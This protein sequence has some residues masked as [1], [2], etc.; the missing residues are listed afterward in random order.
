MRLNPR[1]GDAGDLKALREMMCAGYPDDAF[2]QRL[3]SMQTD[4]S[5]TANVGRAVG[6]AETQGFNNPSGVEWSGGYLTPDT[7]VVTLGGESQDG[8]EWFR[9]HLINVHT[10]TLSG[11]IGVDVT[12]PYELKPLGGHAVPSQQHEVPRVQGGRRASDGSLRRATALL[13]GRST[14]LSF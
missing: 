5:T 8:D 10:G 4:E 13:Q 9:Y 2:R 11:E 12:N 1:T 7:A 14:P 3:G 6:S